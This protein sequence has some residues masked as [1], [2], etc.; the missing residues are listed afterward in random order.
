MLPQAGGGRR[1]LRPAQGG[2]PAHP[3]RPAGR[4]GQGRRGCR[5]AQ[6]R[7]KAGPARHPPDRQGSPEAREYYAGAITKDGRCRPPADLPDANGDYLDFFWA[8]C[9]EVEQTKEYRPREVWDG[10]RYSGKTVL[11]YT[12]LG[13]IADFIAE[14]R[15]DRAAGLPQCAACGKTGDNLVQD[16]EDGLM[17][18]PHCCD[19][20]P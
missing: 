20:E 8:D 15:Q 19:I 18:H 1:W 9:S 13:G 11:R 3:G 5:P 7:S 10:R 14:Q 4:A 16:L 6:G 12:T 2:R 17:K